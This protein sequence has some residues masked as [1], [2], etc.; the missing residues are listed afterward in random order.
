MKANTSLGSNL[1]YEKIEADIQ[2]YMQEVQQKD[3]E[4]DLL[5]DPENS[6][7]EVLDELKKNSDRMKRFVVA[8]ERLEAE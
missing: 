2:K 3:I 8:K 5:Y 1:A 6:G 4:E 7:N